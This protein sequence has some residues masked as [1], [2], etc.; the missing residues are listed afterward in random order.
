MQKE[1]KRKKLRKSRKAIA[2]MC[3]SYLIMAAYALLNERMPI[4]FTIAFLIVSGVAFIASGVFFFTNE[5]IVN[6]FF[7][8]DYEIQE[9]ENKKGEIT[10]RDAEE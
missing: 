9:A 6:D 10:T 2:I 3:V 8:E 1:K 4:Y 5:D 7:L